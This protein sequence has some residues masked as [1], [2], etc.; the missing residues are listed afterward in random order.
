MS[1]PSES[2]KPISPT[3]VYQY[4]IAGHEGKYTCFYS[5]ADLLK[6]YE[7][8]VVTLGGLRAHSEYTDPPPDLKMDIRWCDFQSLANTLFTYGLI[9]IKCK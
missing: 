4:E 2:L 8:G 6:I 3:D 1:N 7:H 5:Y 9:C